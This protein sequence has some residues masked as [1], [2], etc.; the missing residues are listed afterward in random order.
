MV[1]FQ[2]RLHL[3]VAV[4]Y[5]TRDYD[6]TRYSLLMV[7]LSSRFSAAIRLL[8]FFL[9]P[10]SPSNWTLSFREDLC[11]YFHQNTT[12]VCSAQLCYYY[13]KQLALFVVIKLL[14]NDVVEWSRVTN[15]EL[16]ATF[17]ARQGYDEG[18]MGP[19]GELLL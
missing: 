8:S 11:S 14:F 17:D 13:V 2:L 15:N 7:S 5:V 9:S 19:F 3:R 18:E 4:T 12:T 16:C 10:R 6:M 1:T